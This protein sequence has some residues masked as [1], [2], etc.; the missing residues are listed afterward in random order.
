MRK[1]G[2]LL[3]TVSILVCPL[4]SPVSAQ[5]NLPGLNVPRAIPRLIERNILR[6]TRQF[7][8]ALGIVAV[9]AVGAV[10]LGRFSE[11]ERREI[12][13]RAKR[14]VETDPEREVVERYEVKNKLRNVTIK[15]SPAAPKSAFR[16]DPALSSPDDD[17]GDQKK[18]KAGKKTRT[19]DE[20]AVPYDQV[21]EATRCRRVET[22]VAELGN[23]KSDAPPSSDTHA[24]IIC[25][26]TQGD[27]KPTRR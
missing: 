10:I 27:W 13:K 20:D 17:G 4:A 6:S 8:R 22:Q 2:V 25:E 15:A 26:M 23:T 21:P 24:A 9:A 16:D 7:R 3:G 12:A 18:G 5:F 14:A 11:G 1:F 19:A